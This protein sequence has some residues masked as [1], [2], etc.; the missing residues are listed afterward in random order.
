MKKDSETESTV[1]SSGRRRTTWQKVTNYHCSIVGIC[2]RRQDMRAL[3]RKKYFSGCRDGYSDFRMHSYLVTAMATRSEQSRALAKLL[4]AKYR[5]AVKRYATASNEAEIEALWQEDLAAGKIA[6][7]YWAIMTHP[8]AG[9]KYLSS[10]YGHCHLLGYDFFGDY[11]RDARETESLREQVSALEE[12]L[13][14]EHLEHLAEQEQLLQE[15]AVLRERVHLLPPGRPEPQEK[16]LEKPSA[17][18]GAQKE[19]GDRLARLLCRECELVA[20]NLRLAAACEQME[21]ELARAQESLGVQEKQLTRACRELEELHGELKAVE[22]ALLAGTVE[23]PCAECSDVNTEACPGKNLCGKTILY[24]GGQHKMVPRYREMVE[25]LGAQ[26][27]HHDGGKEHARRLLPQLLGGADL[28]FCPVDCVSHDACYCV[29][30]M[31]KRYQKPFVMMRSSG[32]SSLAKELS[33]AVQ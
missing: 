1:S 18:A 14:A 23:E 27:I 19:L 7:G 21:N 24:V 2:L 15:L 4:D 5:L 11:R 33:R 26:F 29:K 10:V 16:V 6:G 12:V 3:S 30:N 17:D 28:V 32:L 31:C 8:A 25:K 9:A 22:L 20:E 13:A